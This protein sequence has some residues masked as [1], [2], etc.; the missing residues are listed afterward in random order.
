MRGRFRRLPGTGLQL[1]ALLACWALPVFASGIVASDL[2]LKDLQGQAQ[3]LSTLRGQ[4]VVVNFWA[5]WR[6]PCARAA[7][8]WLLNDRAGNPPPARVDH[9]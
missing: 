7:V 2:K 1:A 8:E 5:T 3:R 4:F 9:F 6:A